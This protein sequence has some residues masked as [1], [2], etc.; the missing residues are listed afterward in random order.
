MAV[1]ELSLQMGHA[2]VVK[3][4]KTVVY[5][6]ILLSL[7]VELFAEIRGQTNSSG[8]VKWSWVSAISRRRIVPG[9]LWYVL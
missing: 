1:I 8:G 7:L 9:L 4:R 2:Y 6:I 5:M 3:G